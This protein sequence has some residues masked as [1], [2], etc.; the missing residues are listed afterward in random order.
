MTDR[1]ESERCGVRKLAHKELSGIAKDANAYP[2][3]PSSRGRDDL[4][5]HCYWPNQRWASAFGATALK[6]FVCVKPASRLCC[7]S[8]RLPCQGKKFSLLKAENSLR[9]RIGKIS[10]GG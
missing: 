6:N 7:L 10:P 9:W 1:R 5:S 2:E 8:L 3:H 4:A